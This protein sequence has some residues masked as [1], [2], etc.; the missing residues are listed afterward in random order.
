[1]SDTKS[2]TNDTTNPSTSSRNTRTSTPVPSSIPTTTISIPVIPSATTST[3]SDPIIIETE[4]DKEEINTDDMK[5]LFEFLIPGISVLNTFQESDFK[6]FGVMNSH[7]YRKL[8]YKLTAQAN[9]TPLE[10]VVIV[11]LFQ[12]VKNV[13]RVLK[14]IERFKNK[15]WFVSVRKFLVERVVQYNSQVPK[16]ASK[17]AAIQIPHVFPSLTA[18]CWVKTNNNVSLTNFLSNLW[19]VQMNIPINMKNIQ[20]QWETNFWNNTVKK[21]RNVDP[22]LY[23]KGFQEEYWSTKSLDSY[24]FFLPN[25]ETHSVIDDSSFNKWVEAWKK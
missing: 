15:S 6:D 2:S 21:T 18:I 23:E 19:S 8:F 12:K 7:V 20:K 5:E 9:M 14:S 1:M 16:D 4:E 10:I 13:V 17:I 3:P 25:A 24:E 11:T 22:A